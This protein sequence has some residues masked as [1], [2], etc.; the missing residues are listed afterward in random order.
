MFR[1]KKGICTSKNTCSATTVTSCN[2]YL[3]KNLQYDKVEILSE[4]K[5]NEAGW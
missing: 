3:T 1:E 4:I 2:K 5:G